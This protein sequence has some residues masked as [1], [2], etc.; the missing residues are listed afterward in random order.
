MVDK[1]VLANRG[2]VLVHGLDTNCA[3]E[4]L[5]RILGDVANPVAFFDQPMIM[6]VTPLEGAQPTSYAG[7]GQFDLHTDLTFHDAPPAHMAM[8]CIAA[9]EVGGDS[10]L[11]DGFSVFDSF[12]LNE[13]QMFRESLIPFPQPKHINGGR[14][15]LRPIMSGTDDIRLLRFRLDMLDLASLPADIR[16]LLVEF[17]KRA[18]QTMMQFHMQPGELQLVNNHRMLHGRTAITTIPS[19]RHLLR[20]YGSL[21]MPTA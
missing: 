9:D 8:F 10:V 16:N 5:L 7:K 13:Q 19:K 15:V 21:P 17:R 1:D 20:A 14:P 4:E 6:D 18:E 12:S 3:R 11:A 2:Y